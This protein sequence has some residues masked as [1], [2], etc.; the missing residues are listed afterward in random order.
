MAKEPWED[1]VARL[2][3]A[4]RIHFTHFQ[5]PKLPWHTDDHKFG[6]SSDSREVADSGGAGDVDGGEGDDTESSHSTRR[7]VFDS[8][9]T[10]VD[11]GKCYW[12]KDPAVY[13]YQGK[14]YCVD[15][16]SGLEEDGEDPYRGRA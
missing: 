4:K 3:T 8:P 1:D 9:V 6:Q 13:G 5:V 11:Y 15:C 2:S 16:F 14:L 12:C 10:V 7:C